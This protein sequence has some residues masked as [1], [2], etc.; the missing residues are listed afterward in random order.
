MYLAKN[1]FGHSI[2]QK[3]NYVVKCHFLVEFKE[4]GQV[5]FGFGRTEGSAINHT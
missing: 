3:A 4:F 5:C 1:I 2:G